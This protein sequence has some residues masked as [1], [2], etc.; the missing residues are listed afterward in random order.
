MRSP[1]PNDRPTPF[2]SSA[3]PGG[4]ASSPRVRAPQQRKERRNHAVRTTPWVRLEVA[5]ASARARQREVNED[6]HSALDG[7][8]PLFVVADGVG[9]GA[10][11]ARA[12]RELVSQL[13]AALDH[14]R[15]DGAAIRNA[16]LR[17][18]REVGRSIANHTRASGAA[19]VALC[20]GRGRTLSRW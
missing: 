1:M 5:A 11:A 6:W 13:H 3:T 19:T 4:A 16:L 17:A 8:A 20:A 12:S 14:R 2:V 18:D 9:G 15:I 7:D 10:M